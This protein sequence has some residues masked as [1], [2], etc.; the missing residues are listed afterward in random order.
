MSE[1][2]Q[3]QPANAAVQAITGVAQILATVNGYSALIPIGWQAYQHLKAAFSRPPAGGNVVELQVI[4][5]LIVDKADRIVVSG[6][7]FLA[8]LG[9]KQP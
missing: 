5:N 1:Q 7:A 6:E 4:D 2:T 3:Q 9:P 8:E